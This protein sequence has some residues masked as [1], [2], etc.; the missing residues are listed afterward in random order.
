M[1]RPCIQD[2]GSSSDHT[3]DKSNACIL[4]LFWHR[5]VVFGLGGQNHT[6]DMMASLGAAG[7]RSVSRGGREKNVT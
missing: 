5:S 7:P 6:I 1:V 4:F 2:K 3:I